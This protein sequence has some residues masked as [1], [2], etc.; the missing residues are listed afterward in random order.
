[1]SNMTS[2]QSHQVFLGCPYCGN[3]EG[4]VLDEI[5]ILKQHVVSFKADGET[6]FQGDGEV[7]W[8]TSRINP[9]NPTPYTCKV[10]ARSFA[11]P[12][13]VADEA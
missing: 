1:M 11:E 9:E 3:K 12:I 8:N 2:R 4:F 7:D 5:V 6:D 13:P 10:C